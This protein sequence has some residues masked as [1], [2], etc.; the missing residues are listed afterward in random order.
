MGKAAVSA[1]Q[2][3]SFGDLL[4]YLRRREELTQRELAIQVGYSDTQVSRMEQN[5][6]V[7]DKATLKALF[8]PALH[9]QHEPEWADRLLELAGR[10][11]FED[12]LEGSPAEETEIPNN[13]PALL[14]TFVGRV[15]EQ[16]EVRRLLGDHRLVTLTGTGGVGKTR[17]ALKAGSQDLKDYPDGVW[18]VELAP[19][20]DPESLP[21]AAASTLGI[22]TQSTTIA[23]MQVLVNA[24]QKKKA[25]LILDNCEHLL[26]ACARL[27]DGL[28]KNCP[29]LT[30]LATS[31][32]PLGILGEAQYRLPSLGL[33]DDQ[34]DAVGIREY[35]AARLFEDRARLSQPDF[36]LTADNA[37]AIAR[38]CSQLDGIPLAIELAAARVNILT[39]DQIAGRLADCF[40]LLAGGSRTALPRYQ[41]IRAS[42]D[43]SWDLLTELERVL[44]RRLTVFAGGWTLEAAE[45]VC[46]AAG[47]EPLQIPDLLSQLAAKS[48]VMVEH[49]RGRERRFHLHATI[50]QYAREKLAEA[51]EEENLRG[52]HLDYF[53]D[54]SAQAEQAMF[55]PQ[56]KAWFELLTG[57]RE[58][59]RAALE[60]ALWTNAEAGLLLSAR[61]LG[62]WR[63]FDLKEGLQWITQFVQLPEAANFP[64]ARTDARLAQGS[65]LWNM[66]QFEAS[67]EIIEEC[68]TFNREHGRRAGEYFALQLLGGTAQFLEGMDQ[69]VALQTRALAIA[70]EMGDAW[71]EAY[72]LS[73]LGWD[74]RDPH[75]ARQRWEQAITLLRQAGDWRKLAETLGIMGFTVLSN[76]GI[77]EA[78]RYL[79][80]AYEI[81]RQINNREME[82]VLTGKGTLALLKGDYARARALLEENIAFQEE[83]GNRMGTLWAR[84]RIAPI[85]L[86]EGNLEEARQVLME[87]LGNFH[88]DQNRSGL[89]YTLD[90]LASLYAGTGRPEAGA[91]LIG[92]S[93]A[94]REEIGD[95]RPRL[96]QDGVDET[97]AAVEAALGRQ[98][99]EA[100][101]RSGREM[102]MDAVVAFIQAED[103]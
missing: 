19:L 76:G 93:D 42:I 34:Q 15:K 73:N 27:A 8:V 37:Q 95:P 58:N 3:T 41:T 92:W 23:S 2:F 49:A 21:Q 65:L 85:A 40:D 36:S 82:F 38:I 86:G 12:L 90:Q 56:Q 100:A 63:Y 62:F 29:R 47:L 18:L 33:P 9:I 32:Q 97:M 17:L 99:Y 55:G 45:Y 87:A 7:P 35:E 77:D 11:R 31:R 72:A 57:E 13:L 88:T 78:D 103:H 59:L 14:T 68:L 26:D 48:L 44:L 20:S 66:Q 74:Q 70:R 69:K 75:L 24:L 52:R 101:Y 25:L 64:E 50:L 39:P 22:V 84:A 16:A 61:L 4:R 28:L 46:G 1:E 6:R 94:A 5:Q 96:E 54:L 102:S 83:I 30:I 80:E 98:A 10:A 81:N 71:R 91:R 79:E 67:R 60:H 89:A 51:G 53:L 43:W